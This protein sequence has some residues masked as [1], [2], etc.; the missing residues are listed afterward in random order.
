[1]VATARTQAARLAGRLSRDRSAL[2]VL[3]LN[4]R[5]ALSGPLA[6]PSDVPAEAD[7]VEAALGGRLERRQQVEERL[8]VLAIDLREYGRSRENPIALEGELRLAR[9]RWAEIARKVDVCR[10]AHALVRDAYE[11]FHTRDQERLLTCISNHLVTMTNGVL[12]PLEA[13]DTLESVRVVSGGRALEL[14]SPPLSYGEFHAALLSV[15]LGA[16][17]FLARTGVRP[18]FLVDEPFTHLD[19]QRAASVWRLLCSIAKDRQVIVATQD[20]LMLDALEIQPDLTLGRDRSAR[21]ASTPV[22]AS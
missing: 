13:P 8:R 3:D 18:P 11:E 1:M 19:E 22:A 7:A 5:R 21:P 10:R 12:G 15:R 9:Q 6:L 17:D 14:E 16:A 4:L 20:R 2:A